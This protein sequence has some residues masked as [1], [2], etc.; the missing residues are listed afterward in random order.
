MIGWLAYYFN[1]P[2]TRNLWII[3]LLYGYLLIPLF[4]RKY[5]KI[6]SASFPRMRIGIPILLVI[7]T[8]LPLSIKLH[9]KSI[10]RTVNYL[11]WIY[12]QD[13]IPTDT[14]S[15]VILKKDIVTH[16]NRK[17]RYVENQPK[18]SKFE[19]MSAF[20]FTMPIESQRSSFGLPQ[21]VFNETL[22]TTDHE[23]LL[24]KLIKSKPDKILFDD[25]KVFSERLTNW[26]SYYNRWK[27]RIAVDYSLEK[28]T[29]GWHVFKRK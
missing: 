20:A 18:N 8:V 17:A 27:V 12:K 10:T 21:D 9:L 26:E 29:D 28:T 14:Y 16:L 23:I 15:G 5:L 1:R 22:S 6:L 3:I 11:E 19:F 13:R 4:N 25:Y 7:I 24:K 2:A